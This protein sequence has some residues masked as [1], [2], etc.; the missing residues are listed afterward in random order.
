MRTEVLFCPIFAN[1]TQKLK[2]DEADYNIIDADIGSR[3]TWRRS[4]V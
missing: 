4:H 1:P 3:R 2:R